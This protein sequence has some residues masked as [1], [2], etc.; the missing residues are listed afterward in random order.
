[1]EKR[2]YSTPELT[3][4]GDVEALTLATATFGI[5]DGASKQQPNHHSP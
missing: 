1:M 2:A 3:I 4:Y 5:E